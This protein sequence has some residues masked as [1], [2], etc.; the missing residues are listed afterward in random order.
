MMMVVVQMTIVG[1]YHYDYED[2]GDDDQ[3]DAQC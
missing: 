1:A 2:D 3:S